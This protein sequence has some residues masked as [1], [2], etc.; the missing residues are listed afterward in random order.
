MRKLACVGV[1]L[2]G[3]V[4]IAAMTACAAPHGVEVRL[5]NPDFGTT[6]GNLF[7]CS[8]PDFPADTHAVAGGA[9]TC[10]PTSNGATLSTTPVVVSEQMACG[11]GHGALVTVSCAGTGTGED[12]TAT[13]TISITASCDDHQPGSD[14]SGFTFA[15]VAP[16]DTQSSPSALSSC[17][18]FDNICPST[19]DCAFNAFS[20]TV[21]VTNMANSG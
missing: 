20:A 9:I 1:V 14:P 13:V 10:V 2:S 4:V 8:T 7:N 19:N 15:D 5:T 18:V 21:S 3:I 11:D 6:G 17:A 16:G 12:V